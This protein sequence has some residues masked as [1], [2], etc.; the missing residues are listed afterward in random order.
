MATNVSS[1][2]HV[3]SVHLCWNMVELEAC[4]SISQGQVDKSYTHL[5]VHAIL[6]QDESED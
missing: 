6:S 1:E 5:K 3:L 2:M 4:A